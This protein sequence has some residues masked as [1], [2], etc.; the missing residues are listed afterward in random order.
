MNPSEDIDQAQKI[1]NAIFDIN[2]ILYKPEELHKCFHYMKLS[3]ILSLHS[4]AY[5]YLAE[6]SEYIRVKLKDLSHEAFN[7][8]F[9][10]LTKLKVSFE[11]LDRYV[12]DE[13]WDLESVKKEVDQILHDNFK[14]ALKEINEMENK[15]AYIKDYNKPGVEE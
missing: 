8:L 12:K 14:H 1:E 2:H 10:R 13:E 15:H 7:D 11:I 4:F 3:Y 5:S 9:S 6:N